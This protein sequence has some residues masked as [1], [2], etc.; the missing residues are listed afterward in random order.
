MF[1]AK[2]LAAEAHLMALRIIWVEGRGLVFGCSKVLE[3]MIANLLEI[4]KAR[5]AFL[6]YAKVR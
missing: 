4:G 3:Q 6:S 1:V 5:S 2:I